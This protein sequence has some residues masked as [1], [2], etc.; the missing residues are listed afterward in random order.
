MKDRGLPLSHHRHCGS[1]V[2]IVEICLV[3]S[4]FCM[5]RMNRP[6]FLSSSSSIK[7]ASKMF[8]KSTRPVVHRIVVE[9]LE[10]SKFLLES[11]SSQL[12]SLCFSNDDALHK[13]FFDAGKSIKVENKK[14]LFA[15]EDLASKKIC[16]KFAM[17]KKKE[18]IKK[19]VDESLVVKM[20]VVSSGKMYRFGVEKQFSLEDLRKVAGEKLNRSDEIVG[21]FKIRYLDDEGDMITLGTQ[22]EWEEAV[23]ATG[24]LIKVH[25]R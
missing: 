6:S 11:L 15:L 8:L 17:E 20:L 4:A 18:C 19:V 1:C 2:F 24:S 12:N 22:R 21:S 16:T 3:A 13:D 5:Y 25:I 10:T 23:K 14:K 7:S 9:L